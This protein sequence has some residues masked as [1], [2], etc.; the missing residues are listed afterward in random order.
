MCVEVG[1][2]CIVE[3]VVEMMVFEVFSCYGELEVFFVFEFVV[4]MSC[5]VMFDVVFVGFVVVFDF[6]GFVI[7]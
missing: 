7:F 5:C 3:L 6:D 4:E 2:S 1:M